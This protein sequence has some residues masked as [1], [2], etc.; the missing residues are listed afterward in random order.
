[1]AGVWTLLTP[2]DALGRSDLPNTSKSLSVPIWISMVNS[3]VPNP[4][5]TRISSAHLVCRRVCT[6]ICWRD[7]IRYAGK[8][9]IRLAF[10]LVWIQK[11]R[12]MRLCAPI[13]SLSVRTC[14]RLMSG[15]DDLPGKFRFVSIWHRFL[16]EWRPA[17]KRIRISG[18]YLMGELVFRPICGRDQTGN[19]AQSAIRLVFVPVWIQ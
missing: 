5:A 17:A 2:V 15:S 18:A 4:P 6:S 19:G 11:L 12:R 1:V 13:L 7:Q 16:N 10:V 8:T 3:A 9:A 14:V